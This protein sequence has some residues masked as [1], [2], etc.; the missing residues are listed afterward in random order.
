MGDDERLLTEAAKAYPRRF[1]ELYE[2]TSTGCTPSSFGAPATGAK[3]RTSRGVSSCARQPRPVRGAGHPLQANISD[4]CHR[5]GSAKRTSST[6]RTCSAR[7]KLSR[8]TTC[9]DGRHLSAGA[10]IHSDLVEAFPSAFTLQIAIRL[11]DTRQGK[12]LP[13]TLHYAQFSAPS[14]PRPAMTAQP[15]SRVEVRTPLDNT[16]D[17]FLA[18]PP[19]VRMDR[20]D[21]VPSSN[22]STMNSASCGGAWPERP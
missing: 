22:S 7:C 13:D 1:G 8:A 10:R 19:T 3:R 15:V 14:A 12:I 5:N 2:R 4:C 11:L 17:V 21:P 9:G 6:I 20:P 16:I 18:F